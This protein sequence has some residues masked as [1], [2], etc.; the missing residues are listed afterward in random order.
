[1]IVFISRKTVALKF[2]SFYVS[3]IYVT[4]KYP[5]RINKA[6]G[7]FIMYINLSFPLTEC[8]VGYKRISVGGTSS[9]Y[10]IAKNYKVK[11]S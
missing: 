6:P 3:L 2:L 1:M 8:L 11:Y 10:F 4:K 9:Q 5:R 7:N